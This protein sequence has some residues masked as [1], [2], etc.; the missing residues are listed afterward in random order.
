MST[1]I[2]ILFHFI[3]SKYFVVNTFIFL[4]CFGGYGSWSGEYFAYDLNGCFK[5][6]IW[7]L[8]RVMSNLHRWGKL[9]YLVIAPVGFYQPHEESQ[10]CSAKPSAQWMTKMVIIKIWRT[11][12]LYYCNKLILFIWQDI[13]ERVF[14]EMG[15]GS[16]TCL[17]DF[18]Q[19]R[20][21]A[22]HKKKEEQCQLLMA[23]YNRLNK[24]PISIKH[25][26]QSPS[27]TDTL[28]VIRSVI[29]PVFWINNGHF[30]MYV[31]NIIHVMKGKRNIGGLENID[32]FVKW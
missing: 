27:G 29:W 28:H 22:Y 23:E 13:I 24:Q 8:L 3:N 7:L 20:I 9:M 4:F 17:N 5:L 31:I 12:Y 6:R 11:N 18:Y 15:L 26:P 19:Q 1:Y 16:I 32:L 10:I 14:Y 2:V 25:A 30:Q 21:L